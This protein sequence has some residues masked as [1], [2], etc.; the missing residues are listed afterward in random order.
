LREEL[1]SNRGLLEETRR[2]AAGEAERAAQLE[3]L[4][5]TYHTLATQAEDRGRECRRLRAWLWGLVASLAA[6]GLIW[7]VTVVCVALRR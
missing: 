5:A 4:R 7:V 3:T 2:A 1:E 6:A